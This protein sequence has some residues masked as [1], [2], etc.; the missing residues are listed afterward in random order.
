MAAFTPD[1]PTPASGPDNGYLWFQTDTGDTYAW[2]GADWVL[3]TAAGGTGDVNGPAS[4]TDKAIA[5][6]DGAGG[7]T[8]QD[9]T[10][11]L[12]DDGRITTVTDPTGLQDA[13]TKNYVDTQIAAVNVGGAAQTS[14]LV[15]GGQVVWESDY[16]FLVSA[17][18]YYING[19][20]YESAAD[21]VTLGAADPSD[22][23]IDVIAVDD[24]GA[25]VVV[26]GTAA[27]QPSEPDIDPGTQLKLS[28]V[29]VTA[30]TT[31]P[32]AVTSELLYADNAGAP[33]EWNWTASGP[34]IDVNS[35]NNPRSGTKS[36]EGTTVAAGVYAQ[37][38]IGAGTFDPNSVGLLVIYIR[39]KAA[40]TN[41]RGLQVTLRTAN[42]LQGIAVNIERT[43]TWGFDSSITGSYQ[44]VAIPTSQF[45]IP[46]GQ[47]IT[48]VRIADFGGAIGFYL[49]DL[50]FQ[51]G[52]VTQPVN[53]I[54]QEQADARY[55]RLS[56]PL[57]LA[58]SADVSGD[59]PLANLAPAV[60]ASTLLG[61]RSGSAGDWEAIALGTNL[62]MSGSTL[63]ATG[64]GGSGDVV[65][66]ASAVDDRIATFDGTTGKLIQDGG[67]TIAGVEADAV[68]AAVAAI[69]PVDLASEVTGDL[70]LSNLAQASAAS[71]LLGRGSASGAGDFQ[72][73]TLGTGL[74]LTGTV[75]SATA[76]ASIRVVACVIDGGSAVITTGLKGF[77]R[78]PMAGTITKVTVLSIDAAGPATAGDIVI[79]V[80][81]DTYANY[82][83]T[84]ADSIVASAPPTLS[85]A[86]K[87]EDSTLT[88]WT[89][90][91]SA[92]DVFGFYVDS[93]AL[94]T[95]VLVEIEVTT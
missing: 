30:G 46:Q 83:P 48:Q 12:E 79:D 24:A 14:F 61:R 47:T 56:V 72:E 88:G 16:I 32:P 36:I 93:A 15:S 37:G 22:D 57:A 51:G 65:G 9:S 18:V 45:A 40:W 85:S 91:V 77:V 2:D 44:Q 50:S 13:A 31:E 19:V 53:G 38:E 10:P 34:S 68:T 66:P 70:P 60:G 23:R 95:K 54:T 21:S 5:R 81:K 80:W 20:L 26:P 52:A 4:S 11:I 49:D 84:A 6:W 59:L 78:F 69:I 58:S 35:T 8:L 87:S 42:V 73:I 39:S 1:P 29:L 33:T 90:S 94:V 86:N 67:K 89:T 71:R 3:I 17:A 64:G 28:I 92:G 25:V 75:L 74:A 76:A 43:G 41:K 63:N 55:R 27:A 82:P 7:D 62:S